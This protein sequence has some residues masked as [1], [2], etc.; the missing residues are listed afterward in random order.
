MPLDHLTIILQMMV[1]AKL[2][3]QDVGMPKVIRG[4]GH[5]GDKFKYLRI[6]LYNMKSP[7]RRVHSAD[8]TLARFFHCS[9]YAGIKGILEDRMFRTKDWN[10][11]GAGH[12]GIYGVAYLGQGNDDHDEQEM[13]RC[14]YKT[15]CLGK[16]VS[17]MII[18]AT[19][20]GIHRTMK[21]GGIEGEER[22][23]RENVFV[24]Y[25]HRWCFHP[26]STQIEAL[27][28]VGAPAEAAVH[29]QGRVPRWAQ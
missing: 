19:C 29:Y 4:Q 8:E 5:A 6:P 25:G 16:N 10:Q 2:V 22:L 12:H 20:S 15:A 11:G 26:A 14:I 13:H 18:E 27:W 9:T 28:I 7:K 23:V 3:V 17:N 24:H 1:N 21:S